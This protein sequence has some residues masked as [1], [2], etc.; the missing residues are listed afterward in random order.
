[1]P[2]HGQRHRPTLRDVEFRLLGPVEVVQDRSLLPVGGRRQRAV[3]AQ[4]ALH[5]GA[6]LA[7]E[8]L[9]DQVWGDR[10]PAH[11][12]ASLHT[13]VSRL[14]AV[15][16]PD[17][18]ETRSTGYVLHAA[19]DEVDALRFERLLAEATGLV[20]HDPLTTFDL[21]TEALAL[22]RGPAL[23]D[24]ADEPSLRAVATRLE[25]LHEEAVERRL[26]AR[27][28]CGDHTGL[29][30]ELEGLLARSPLREDLWAAYVLA[31]YR[32]GRAAEA[33]AACDRARHLLSDELG[34]EPGAQL[35]RLYEQVL[36]QDP[37]LTPHGAALH[38]YRLAGVLGQ[39][40]SAV[41]HRALQPWVGRAVA[42]KVLRPAVADDPR[43]VHGF[44]VAVQAAAAVEHPHVLPLLE[45][46]RAPGEAVL[47]L[48]LAPGGTLLD[49]VTARPPDLA[50][51]LRLAGRLAGALDACA[52]CG[53]VHTQLRARDVL[54]DAQ[55]DPQLSP[56]V[57]T[58]DLAPRPD[59]RAPDER[60]PGEAAPAGQ[61][62]ARALAGLLR[63]LLPHAS[64]AVQEVLSRAGR[65][66]RPGD[67][68]TL[69]P[70]ALD[71]HALGPQALDPQALVTALG[72]A[73][74]QSP[75]AA[76]PPVPW[77]RRPAPGPRPAGPGHRRLT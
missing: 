3:L 73:L 36:R 47:V 5:P 25:A 77:P 32:C 9:V 44:A 41:V 13:Y 74:G 58:H 70:Q 62:H 26:E 53:V 23:G 35:R 43:V 59:E 50:E 28:A 66:G 27:L 31:L 64:A 21:L 40:P 72:T 42:L 16:G 29:V 63:E 37:E 57:L 20:A 19:P 46:W 10:P 65:D 71:P 14:R 69:E 15:L 6:P 76:R 67:P 61:V 52:R 60:A 1:M 34:V 4:L 12:R 55:G 38:G 49:R 11:V 54:L 22:W 33:V 51:V 18:L 39:G 17:R 30:P 2:F 48:R 56:F 7:P 8:R 75:A 24:L 45:C 68:R